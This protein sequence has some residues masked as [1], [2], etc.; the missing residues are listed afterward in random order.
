MDPGN[1]DKQKSKKRAKLGS[2]EN[3]RPDMKLLKQPAQK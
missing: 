3:W 1:W 2:K